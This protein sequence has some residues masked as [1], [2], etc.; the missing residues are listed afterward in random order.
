MTRALHKSEG[1]NEMKECQCKEFY[2]VYVAAEK[3][4]FFSEQDL[5]FWKMKRARHMLGSL[6][7]KHQ[8]LTLQKDRKI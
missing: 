4:F 3:L 7:R 5:W 6:I 2:E 8:K 1:L